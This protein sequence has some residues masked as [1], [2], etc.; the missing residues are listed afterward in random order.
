VV[1]DAAVFVAEDAVLN[2][3]LAVVF[4]VVIFVADAIAY[5]DPVVAIRIHNINSY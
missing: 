1:V 3:V 5:Q 4:F 2:A